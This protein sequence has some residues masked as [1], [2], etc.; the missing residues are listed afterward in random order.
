MA[1]EFLIQCAL[2]IPLIGAAFI[3]LANFDRNLREA[4][5]MITAAAL[6]MVVVVN[7]SIWRMSNFGWP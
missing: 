5:T 7:P 3:A 4:V 2:A 1:G 6:F